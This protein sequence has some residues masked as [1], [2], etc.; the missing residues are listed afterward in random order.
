[1]TATTRTST[2]RS[3]SVLI[4]SAVF[5]SVWATALAESDGFTRFWPIVIFLVASVISMTGLGYA[6][7]QLPVSV[8]YAVWTGVGAALTVIIAIAMGNETMTVWKAVFLSG[9]VAAVI[10]LR[11]VDSRENTNPNG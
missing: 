11:L 2:S 5:E 10:G 7:K 1:M 4:G 9:I 6:M 3:W 8:S